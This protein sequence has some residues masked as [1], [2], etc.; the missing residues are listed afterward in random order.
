MI[1]N[2]KSKNAAIHEI[3]EQNDSDIADLEKM[4]S[5][6]E[7]ENKK[8]ASKIKKLGQENKILTERIAELEGK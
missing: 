1:T 4:V 5:E 6:T 7:A 3:K 8:L 2:H